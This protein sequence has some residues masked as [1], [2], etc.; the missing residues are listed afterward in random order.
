M[1]T[2]QTSRMRTTADIL[3]SLSE[4]PELAITFHSS[5]SVSIQVPEHLP[6][7]DDERMA[8]TDRIAQAFGQK[9]GVRSRSKDDVSLVTYGTPFFSEPAVYAP[10]I[11]EKS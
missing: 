9:C 4:L 8:L 5:E 6:L 2:T 3:D 1:T 11:R 10:G 7:T